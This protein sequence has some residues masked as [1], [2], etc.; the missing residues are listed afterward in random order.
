[1]DFG[2]EAPASSMLPPNL[3]HPQKTRR[4]TKEEWEAQRPFIVERYHMKEMTLPK[5]ADFLLEERGFT[6]T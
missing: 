1:M 5:I 2:G 4:Y 3:V 6:A